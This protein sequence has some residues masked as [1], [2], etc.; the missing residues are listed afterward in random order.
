[1]LK[2]RLQRGDTLIEVLFAVSVFSFVVVSALTIMNQGTA[3]SQRSLEITLVRQQVDAQAETLRF[4]HDAY[5]AAYQSHI[6]FNTTDAA[7]SPAEEWYKMMAAKGNVITAASAFESAATCPAAPSGAFIV[8]PRNVAFVTKANALQPS[9]NFSQVT[10]Q[11]NGVF[12]SAKG[13]WV[14]AVRSTLS[15]E[16]A[17]DGAQSNAGYVDFHIRA[18]WES[19]GLPVASRTGT[20]VRLY[21]PRG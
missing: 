20:I 18:C 19:A 1:M 8:D 11:S 9:T 2:R 13:L 5:V 7:T 15:A 21:E 3:A 12:D 6:V 4:M 17:S 16:Q 14:E 10:Y